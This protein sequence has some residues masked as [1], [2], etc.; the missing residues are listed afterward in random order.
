MGVC[1]MC[2]C[3]HMG[4]TCMCVYGVRV[5]VHAG[6][7]CVCAWVSSKARRRLDYI[8]STLYLAQDLKGR[9]SL[10]LL[11]TQSQMSIC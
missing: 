3:V 8:W 2:V 11:K 7:T 10:V 5:H 6:I 4:I 9:V 1:G